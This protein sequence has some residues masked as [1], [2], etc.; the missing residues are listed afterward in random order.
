MTLRV[1]VAPALLEWAAARA[2]WSADDADAKSNGAYSAWVSGDKKPTLKQL[3]R[4]AQRTRAPLG[5]FFLPE[6]P[7]EQIPLPDFR[8]LGGGK[9]ERPSPELLD[10]IYTMQRRQA[11]LRETLIEQG[12]EPLAFVGSATV[13]DPPE[14][15][16]AEMR[17][18]IG[19]AEGW[20]KSVGTW[21]AAVTALRRG[22]E[23]LGVMA[24]VNGVVGN[25]T[26]RRL[27]VDEFRGFAMS[28]PYAPLVFV[29]G[30]D[31][32]SAQMFTLAHEL[33]HLWLGVEALSGFEGLL[34]GEGP[35]GGE[36]E[37]WCNTAAAE[38]L[39]PAA[40]LREMWPSV[41]RSD[42]R[43]R[44][45]A[46]AFKVSPVVVARRALDLGLVGRHEFFHFYRG[47]MAAATRGSS[48]GGGDFY[49]NQN[50]RVGE[51]FGSHVI[52]AALEGR[53]GSRRRTT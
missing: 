3:E 21:E 16:A 46:R 22:I 40:Q 24:V 43:Y 23:D 31:A 10:T 36:V 19:I 35:E 27:D 33:A 11:W 32:K 15:I 13:H 12:V 47:Y 41:K 17:R 6:P 4:F 14:A 37:R 53:V 48:A 51:L 9:L 25:N 2:G 5:Y 49:N 34:P 52:R 26:Y 42:Q 7:E 30:A 29:N 50:T 20:A 18:A 1:D 44:R 38:F 45:A 28:D 8:T 39:V